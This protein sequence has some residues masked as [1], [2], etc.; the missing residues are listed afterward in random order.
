[1]WYARR[2]PSCAGTSFI[3][4]LTTKPELLTT[5]VKMGIQFQQVLVGYIKTQ[6]QNL[7]WP[8]TYRQYTQTTTVDIQLIDT[9][10]SWAAGPD[11]Q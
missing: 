6:T 9:L 7:A 4:F 1:M 2:V 3:K 8:I 5:N 10:Y 11:G